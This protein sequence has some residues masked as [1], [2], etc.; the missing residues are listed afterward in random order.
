MARKSCP[1]T[2]PSDFTGNSMMD[3]SVLPVDLVP[4]GKTS[5]CQVANEAVAAEGHG[6]A[7][8]RRFLSPTISHFLESTSKAQDATRIS[9]GSRY[10]SGLRRHGKT[11]G[12]GGRARHLGPPGSKTKNHGMKS[13]PGKDGGAAGERVQLAAVRDQDGAHHGVDEAGP[14]ELRRGFGV[15][16]GGPIQG[17]AHDPGPAPRPHRG[18]GHA[19]PG[20]E[21]G[22]GDGAG[23]DLEDGV[24]GLL[25]SMLHHQAASLGGPANASKPSSSSRRR[26]AVLALP[27]PLT[28]CRR[29]RHL[30]GNRTSDSL[31]DD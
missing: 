12:G 4:G 3:S 6:L 23:G 9:G 22:A 20:V 7:D 26:R 31:L 17:E 19:A 25:D 8:E 14:C 2:M 21:Q 16:D 1:G 13:N 10:S 29:R 27:S 11:G 15:V 28:A 18:E 30:G 24:G 5:M